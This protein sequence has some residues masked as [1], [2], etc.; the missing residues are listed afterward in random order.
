VDP[1]AL[2]PETA[3]LRDRLRVFLERELLPA[4]LREG[5]AHNHLWQYPDIPGVRMK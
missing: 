3:A 2:P 1:H 4:E 5:V